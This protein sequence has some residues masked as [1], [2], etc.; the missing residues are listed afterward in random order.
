MKVK[1]KAQVSLDFLITLAVALSIFA[2]MSNAAYS[3]SIQARELE[4][5]VAATEIIRQYSRKI[6]AAYLSPENSTLTHTLP[7]SI[8]GI[9]YEVRV[10]SRSIAIVYYTG[11]T[12]VH[13]SSILSANIT[14][15]SGSKPGDTIR[16]TKTGGHI[17]IE[18]AK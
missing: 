16:I 18:D 1:S 9:P 14:D 13:S 3:Q 8:N 10:T 4:N 6:N 2:V 11:D 7:G 12:R 5:T 15:N 17:L